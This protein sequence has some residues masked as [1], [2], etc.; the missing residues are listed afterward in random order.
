[1]EWPS[2]LQGEMLKVYQTIIL[3]SSNH[4]FFSSKTLTELC[5]MIATI[6][7]SNGAGFKTY[8]IQEE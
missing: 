7:H 2:K 1:M 6:L 3:N 5:Q 8:N 4:N